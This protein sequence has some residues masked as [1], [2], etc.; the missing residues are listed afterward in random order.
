MNLQLL[1]ERAFKIQTEL[2]NLKHEF[3]IF[4]MDETIP[5]VTRWDIFQKSPEL[6][7]YKNNYI[8]LFAVEYNE[9]E[10]IDWVDEGYDKYATIDL[11]DF[12]NIA[13]QTN[14]YSPDIISKMKIDLLHS[15]CASCVFDW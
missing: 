2:D 11:I 8:F 6:L 13:E 4:L 14:R 5:L 3:E 9:I 1:I 12:V 7:K 15:N 10:C